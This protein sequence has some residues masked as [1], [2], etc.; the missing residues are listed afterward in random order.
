MVD[1]KLYESM[2]ETFFDTP[3]KEGKISSG[4]RTCWTRGDGLVRASL[5]E[6]THSGYIIKANLTLEDLDR[7]SY[8]LGASSRLL[9][10]N[11]HQK[12]RSVDP[13]TIRNLVDGMVMF[14]LSTTAVEMVGLRA[15]MHEC[16]IAI[17]YAR[18]EVHTAVTDAALT[19][20]GPMYDATLSEAM[21]T[22]KA[23][24]DERVV[25]C[26]RIAE[27][28]KNNEGAITVCGLYGWEGASFDR[29]IDS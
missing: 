13:S 6:T 8:G 24:H 20:Q 27:V 12:F 11:I 9:V 19:G 3:W 5:R 17:N 22:L 29:N 18:L 7:N 14:V 1:A 23:V 28:S 15:K 2:L 16:D 21:A 4:R 26:G 25:V 10:E